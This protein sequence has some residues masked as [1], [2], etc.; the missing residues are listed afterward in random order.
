M[1]RNLFGWFAAVGVLFATSCAKDV[2]DATVTGD[3]AVVTFSLGLENSVNTRT[4]SDGTGADMLVY[5]LYDANGNVLPAFEQ[6]VDDEATF[7]YTLTLRLIKG[8]T[9]KIAFWAQNKEC[10]AYNTEDL[11]A[12]TVDYSG[13]NN[14]ETRDA[15]F[16]A[17]TF[18]VSGQPLSSTLRRPFAQ[19][20]LGA[21]V[22]D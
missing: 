12:V 3:E 14:D 13:L 1:K 18:T 5:Q 9:Y 6:V 19:L 16:S 7:P 8:Q 17:E 20:N 10:T 11:T 21:T 4:I 22:E 15:F 2:S